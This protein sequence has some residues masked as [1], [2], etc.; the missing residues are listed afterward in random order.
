MRFTP[1]P[2][3]SALFGLSWRTVSITHPALHYHGSIGNSTGIASQ[4]GFGF[5]GEC[6]ARQCVLQAENNSVRNADDSN[7]RHVLLL[8]HDAC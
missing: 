6:P 3:F 7:A 8:S 1:A 2:Q 4:G 5:V